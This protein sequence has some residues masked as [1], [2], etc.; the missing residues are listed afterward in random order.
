[1]TWFSEKTPE[2]ARAFSELRT[3]IP[4]AEK[5]AD[6]P[7]KA[8]GFISFLKAKGTSLFHNAP[9]LVIEKSG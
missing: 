8:P 6:N 7:K 3:M 9:L 4:L 1:M 2:A 5:I